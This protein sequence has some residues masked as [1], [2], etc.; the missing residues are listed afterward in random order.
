MIKPNRTFAPVQRYTARLSA[1]ATA[2][3]L[4]LACAPGA[5]AAIFGDDE[6]RKAILEI[7]KLVDNQGKE[8]N[9][10]TER[11][12]DM[13]Q[14]VE[15]LESASRGNLELNNQ[16]E[17]MRAE[18]AKLRGQLE[19]QT[20]ELATTQKRQRDLFGDLD[21][22]VK[23]FEP[24]TT[25]VDGRDITVE[26][27]EKRAY[28][29]ALQLF[30]AG[31]FKA[32]VMAF[33]SLRKQ[34]PKSGYIPS[35][36]Y[37]AGNAHYALRDYKASIAAQQEV[38]RQYPDNPRVPDAMLNMAASQLELGDKRAARKTLETIID[39]FPESPAAAT[40]KERLPSVK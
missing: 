40:A 1:L 16:L 38:A 12:V 37:W 23:R 34:F 31:D 2:A 25:T 19:A 8:L 33:D 30:K 13:N 24:Q 26:P 15:R 6:A 18:I 20:N 10:L 4:G 21:G 29:A 28:D 36:M 27:Q 11:L 35:A 17:T 7:R 9:R 22:R 3:M 39:R 32:A 5:Q 14:R